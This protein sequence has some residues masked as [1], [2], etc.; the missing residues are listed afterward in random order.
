[1][2]VGFKDY[3]DGSGYNGFRRILGY[4]LDK[5][6]QISIFPLNPEILRN[7]YTFN[8]LSFAYSLIH[9]ENHRCWL[10]KTNEY[11]Y[12]TMF[13]IIKPVPLMLDITMSVVYS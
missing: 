3:L 5:L 8:I 4:A 6:I 9:R 7:R 1:M 13:Y 10:L 11:V 2:C 12:Y